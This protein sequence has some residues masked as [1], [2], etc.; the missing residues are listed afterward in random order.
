MTLSGV[1]TDDL[2]SQSGSTHSLVSECVGHNTDWPV[3]YGDEK[4]KGFTRYVSYETAKLPKSCPSSELRR[5]SGQAFS[6]RYPRPD[7][8]AALVL[9]LDAQ[10]ARMVYS[11]DR[12]P[13][14]SEAQ[15]DRPQYLTQPKLLNA[16]DPVVLHS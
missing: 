15:P 3:D 9:A 13:P 10:V 6:R 12:K 16:V 2:D 5:K 1:A 11:A 14:R 4:E 8:P 7:T